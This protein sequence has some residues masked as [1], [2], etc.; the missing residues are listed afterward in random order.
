M[1]GPWPAKLLL[2]PE[3]LFSHFPY[4]AFFPSFQQC[5]ADRWKWAE[6]SK[7]EQRLCMPTFRVPV[8][9]VHMS[10]LRNGQ[11]GRR[12]VM[13]ALSR[14]F[15]HVH[16]RPADRVRDVREGTARQVHQVHRAA[17][18]EHGRRGRECSPASESDAG[19]SPRRAVESEA[20]GV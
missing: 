19:L 16:H 15:V 5:H 2:A 9:M 11:W 20:S 17:A 14:A 18:R 7:L 1:V 10:G 12:G 4:G 8:V 6:A 13:R 3:W